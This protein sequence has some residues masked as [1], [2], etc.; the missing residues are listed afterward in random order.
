[1]WKQIAIFVG[2]IG[3]GLIITKLWFQ[4]VMGSNFPDWIKYILLH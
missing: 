2:L 1:M 4:F 3:L